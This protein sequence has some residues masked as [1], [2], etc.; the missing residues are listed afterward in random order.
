MLSNIHDP[1]VNKPSD[2]LLLTPCGVKTVFSVIAPAGAGTK[3]GGIVTC[4]IANVINSATNY[5]ILVGPKMKM[6]MTYYFNP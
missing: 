1:E 2:V 6:T 4:V 5:D 3:T